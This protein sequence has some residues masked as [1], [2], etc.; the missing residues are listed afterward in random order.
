[1]CIRGIRTPRTFKVTKLLFKDREEVRGGAKMKGVCAII[2]H[3]LA[4][5][6]AGYKALRKDKSFA[7]NFSDFLRFLARNLSFRV[8]K[9]KE[10]F[11][12]STR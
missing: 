7:Q 1:M 11:S 3:F 10:H 12:D 9:I 6:T 5:L 8:T 4:N 2:G